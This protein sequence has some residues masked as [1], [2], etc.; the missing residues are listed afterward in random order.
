MRG[1]AEQLQASALSEALQAAGW[2]V[3]T[4]QSIH[5][6]AIGVVFV[7]ILMIALRVLGWARMDQSP[8]AVVARFAPWL[9]GGLA[10][11]ATTG[12]VL[13]LAEPVREIMNASF[14]TKMALLLVAVASAAW[15]GRTLAPPVTADGAAPP[16]A[17]PFTPAAK[18]LAAGT[19]V[20]WLAIIFLG[21]AIAYDVEVWGALSPAAAP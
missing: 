7:S 15:F 19:V 13:V 18:A 3:P 11:M 17:G 4:V 10:V 2:I 9:W 21:R 8:A 1:F 5:I 14:R 6:L 16:E 12:L 20:L